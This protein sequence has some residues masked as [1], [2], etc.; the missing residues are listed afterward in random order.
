MKIRN[1][2]FL[3]LVSTMLE[4][5]IIAKAKYPSQVIWTTRAMYR[6]NFQ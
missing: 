6:F 4:I 5:R 1:A 2:I 3:D